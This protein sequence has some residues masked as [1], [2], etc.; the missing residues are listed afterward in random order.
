LF[1]L[2]ALPHWLTGRARNAVTDIGNLSQ[3]VGA[4]SLNDTL[5]A[6]SADIEAALVQHIFTSANEAQIFQTTWNT[7][8]SALPQDMTLEELLMFL[9][10][11]SDSDRDAIIRLVNQRLNPD[12]DP[13][14]VAQDEPKR[15]RILTMHGAKGLHGKVVFIPSVEQGILPS[16]RNLQAAGL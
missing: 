10:T 6:R 13:D 5:A 16:F 4:W 11:S 8:A 9:R 3:L 1:H 7:V 12:V 15:V 2:Q 14:S